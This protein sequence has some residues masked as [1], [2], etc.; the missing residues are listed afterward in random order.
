M[1]KLAQMGNDSH[2]VSSIDFSNLTILSRY[3]DRNR[4]IGLETFVYCSRFC[5]Y[6]YARMTNYRYNRCLYI[7]AFRFR[8]LS[9]KVIFCLRSRA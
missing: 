8:D 2:L 4:E 1:V 7:W 6:M 3:R 5:I 9:L